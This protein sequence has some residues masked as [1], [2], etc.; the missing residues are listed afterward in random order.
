MV[1]SGNSDNSVCFLA[2][3]STVD[4]HFEFL[5]SDDYFKKD[6]QWQINSCFNSLLSGIAD[7]SS[8]SKAV[9]GYQA[10]HFIGMPECDV[11]TFILLLLQH[12]L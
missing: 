10:C 5:L 7:S 3:R 2:M 6:G 1:E 12:F 4:A 8:L 9:A 11:R